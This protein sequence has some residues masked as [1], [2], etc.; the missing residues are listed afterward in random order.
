MVLSRGCISSY[1]TKSLNLEDFPMVKMDSNRSQGWLLLI[2]NSQSRFQYYTM[3]WIEWLQYSCLEHLKK[4]NFNVSEEWYHWIYTLNDHLIAPFKLKKPSFSMVDDISKAFYESY[5]KLIVMCEVGKEIECVPKLFHPL[6][7]THSF[8]S[9]NAHFLQGETKMLVQKTDPPARIRMVDSYNYHR[10]NP[11]TGSP[12]YSLHPL[13]KTEND[14]KIDSLEENTWLQTV[15]ELESM[16]R[17]HFNV[18]KKESQNIK[19]SNGATNGANRFSLRTNS[20]PIEDSVLLPLAIPRD[21]LQLQKDPL[22]RDF[23]QKDPLQRSLSLNDIGTTPQSAS[24]IQTSLQN[25]WTVQNPSTAQTIYFTSRN[26]KRKLT[27]L[28]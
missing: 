16:T 25:T 15:G 9:Y 14:L 4:T 20:N 12:I 2:E 23:L 8:Q 28:S 21:T 10:A 1:Q 17:F 6:S 7:N 11:Q 22:Q 5:Q 3:N 27:I 24:P 13:P 19:S 26:R 18:E